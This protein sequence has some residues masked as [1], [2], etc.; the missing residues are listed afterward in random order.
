MSDS[1]QTQSLEPE[2]TSIEPALEVSAFDEEFGEPDA[3]EADAGRSPWKWLLPIVVVLIGGAVSWLL[4]A[5]REEP[6]RVETTTPGPLVETQRIERQSV[7][8]VVDAEGEVRARRRVQLAPQVTGR[9]TAMHGSFLAGGRF[10]AGEMLLRIDPSDFDLA[11]A[12]ARASVARAETQLETQKAEAAAAIAEWQELEPELAPPPLA[13]REPQIRQAEAEVAAAE[14]DL[15]R[16]ELNLQRTRLSLP[17][18]GVVIEE[19]VD[20]GQ[21][22]NAGQ[23]IATVYGTDAVEVRVPLPDDELRWFELPGGD[24]VAAMAWVQ[25]DIAGGSHRWRGAVERL[26]GEVDPRSRMVRA[27]VRV[28]DPFSASDGRPPLLPGSFV[29]VAI[30][31]Q[32]LDDVVPI[33]REALRPNDE[34]WVVDGDRLRVRSVDVARRDRKQAL[35]AS[36][37]DGGELIVVSSLDAVTDGM[38][39]RVAADE[40][41]SPRPPSVQDDRPAPTVEPAVPAGAG[42]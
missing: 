22:V 17:F 16:A 8:I 33:P 42:S 40:A 15:R 21:L 36:G 30:D 7:E 24:G 18:D 2:S 32:R 26:E 13:R 28:D 6:E 23:S 4:V 11:V 35:V 31:G 14:A 34:V 9:V 39:V 5:S 37:L 12:S 38:V 20:V 41:P 27:V 10:G 19:S 25:A 3:A 1:D 29:Q